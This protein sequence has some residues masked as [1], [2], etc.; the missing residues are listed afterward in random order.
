MTFIFIILGFTTMFVFL[1]KRE[2]LFKKE[3][4]YSLFLFNT[5]LFVSAFLFTYFFNEISENVVLLKIP[6]LSQ[7]IFLLM[8]QIFRKFY[9]KNPEDTFWSMNSALIKDGVFNFIFWI[10][11]ILLPLL[12]V[13]S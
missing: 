2:I 7:I 1:F 9:K 6:I 10:T 8:I 3:T 11:G 12:L 5:V 4:F 13:T